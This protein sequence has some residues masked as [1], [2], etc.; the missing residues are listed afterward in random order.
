MASKV[1]PG[2]P[3]NPSQPVNLYQEDRFHLQGQRPLGSFPLKAQ[4]SFMAE[5]VAEPV[6]DGALSKIYGKPQL[7]ARPQTSLLSLSEQARMVWTN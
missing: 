4:S 5:S 1:H 2:A 3:L 7:F 6:A